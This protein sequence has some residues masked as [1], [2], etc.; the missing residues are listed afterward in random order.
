MTN[1]NDT[2]GT[3]EKPG[4]AFMK[5]FSSLGEMETSTKVILIVAGVVLAIY[6]AG[7][8][9]FTNMFLPNTTLAGRDVSFMSTTAVTSGL[10]DETDGFVSHVSGDG[11]DMDI[12]ASE[13]DLEFDA[14]AYIKSALDQENPWFWPIGIFLH[15][16]IDATELA[17]LD[18]DKL[19]AIVKEAVDKINETGTAPTDATIAYSDDEASFVVV[20]EQAGTKLDEQKV[21]DEIRAG[22][23]SLDKT[24]ELDNAAYLMPE[25]LS[26]DPSLAAAA[27]K[28]NSFLTANISLSMNGLDAGTIDASMIQKWVT[29]DENLDSTLD[30]AAIETWGKEELSPTLD[31]VGTTRTYTRP[32]GK[33]VTVSGGYYGWN[34]DSATLSTQIVDAVKN[35]ETTTI[36]VPTYSTAAQLPDANGRD[37]GNRYIDVDLTEQ[38]ARMYDDSGNLVWETDFVSGN[39][40]GNY[41]TP[42]GVYFINSY[43]NKSNPQSTLLGQTDPET[44]EPEYETPVYYWMPFIDNMVGFHD[45][46]WRSSFGG[47]IYQGNGSHGCINLPSEKASELCELIQVGDV[48]VVHN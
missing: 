23:M 48:V 39:T 7:V 21:F 41:N 19:Q 1:G 5:K 34:I 25:V 30:E 44:N 13:V 16:E 11:I 35:G 45:A 28:A 17:S 18:D 22:L 14:E 32:D 37:W 4:L 29:L 3:P 2:N 10:S 43:F 40:V 26:D 38:H 36:E 42:T 8:I 27:E 24:I 9:V 31:T 47:T 46:Y 12:T 33:T 20:A 6:L 15:H